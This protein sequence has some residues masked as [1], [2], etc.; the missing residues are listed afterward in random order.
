MW[1]RIKQRKLIVPKDWLT[2]MTLKRLYLKIRFPPTDFL[3]YYLIK[4][5]QKMELE[6]SY[7]HLSD[8][9]C[10]IQIFS[11]PSLSICSQGAFSLNL[12]VNQSGGIAI[13][14]IYTRTYWLHLGLF[15]WFKGIICEKIKLFK[16]LARLLECFVLPLLLW[17]MKLA[18]L[19]ILK[20]WRISI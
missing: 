14:D 19:I 16:R 7:F 12:P 8:W 9:Y 5:F 20:F 2:A 6:T 17:R 10:Q 3:S 18:I 13:L 1:Y 11:L 15:G 4:F